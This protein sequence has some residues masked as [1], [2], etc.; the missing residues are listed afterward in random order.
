MLDVLSPNLGIFPSHHKQIVI[1]DSRNVENGR[2]LGFK[3]PTVKLL[4]I[5]NK[6]KIQ[7]LSKESVNGSCFINF[8]YISALKYF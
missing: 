6:N 1:A 4:C 2:K 8:F 5:Q 7:R 3:G